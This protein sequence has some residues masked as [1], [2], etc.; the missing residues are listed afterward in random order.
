MSRGADLQPSPLS[1][2][3]NPG[4]N[5][6]AAFVT[7]TEAEAD[8]ENLRFLRT[9]FEASEGNI[10][11]PV[12]STSHLQ[13]ESA[14]ARR[15]H[16]RISRQLEQLNANTRPNY[17]GNAEAQIRRTHQTHDRLTRVM[18]RISRVHD[19][20]REAGRQA[21][22]YLAERRDEANPPA[23]TSDT[24][25]VQGV[26]SEV[27][28]LRDI[29][30]SLRRDNPHVAPDVSNIIPSSRRA[31]G[32]EREAVRSSGEGSGENESSSSILSGLQRA[33]REVQALERRLDATER[34][35]EFTERHADSL[36]STAIMQ[37]AR[38][39]AASTE[40]M[41]RYIRNREQLGGN[42]NN[43]DHEGQNHDST[44]LSRW[45]RMSRNTGFT[46]APTTNTNTIVP[47]LRTV[48]DDPQAVRTEG[49]DAWMRFFHHTDNQQR[50]NPGR[51]VKAHQISVSPFLIN[52]VVYL[53]RLRHCN[54][55][56]DA[57]VAA[58]EGGFANKEFFADK[59]DDF[60]MDVSNFPPPLRSSW[61]QS[62]V[63]FS[64]SQHTNFQQMAGAQNGQSHISRVEARAASARDASS[65]QINSVAQVT[66]ARAGSSFP[67][68]E[69]WPVKVLLHA[70]DME[71]MT[72]SGTM[73]AYDI[74]N[75]CT[76]KDGS[77]KVPITT[78]LEGQIIDLKTH[79]FLTPQPPK[80]ATDQRST[81]PSAPSTKINFPGT[82]AAIDA[83][84]WRRLPPFSFISDDTEV[85]RLMLSQDR[86]AAVNDEYIFMRWKERCFIH[87]A[88]DACPLSP[89]ARRRGA[90]PLDAA[91]YI[92]HTGFAQPIPRFPRSVVG[93]G[94]DTDCGH[95]LTISGFYYVSL[96]RDG[97]ELAGLYY[98][99]SSTPYQFLHLVGERGGRSAAW[100]F[101]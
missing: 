51:G 73:E 25:T 74:P 88:G 3:S 72:L 81:S 49:E 80:S 86:M 66:D 10:A 44:L 47:E 84:N 21:A 63:R 61:L 79:S 67:A 32:N 7:P 78:F 34:R 64:G 24:G 100:A 65:G 19:A 28:E 5:I 33:E 75:H 23:A 57:L 35:L 77:K 96:R 18:S 27:A 14:E 70:V 92:S 48:L 29:L 69:Q 99:Q 2:T 38:T 101:R 8:D 12:A 6:G 11:A 91:R 76:P 1:Y 42:N 62:G 68:L 13:A 87:R 26:V 46:D 83:G 45:S 37:N 89:S 15:R 90:S 82:S 98:D 59:H 39:N 85:S 43:N 56:D 41:L 95:G 50:Q 52:T 71:S 53:E 94:D 40:R 97:G 36:R 9:P 55:Y 4:P 31:V 17:V 20:G 54:S 30:E 60:I 93:E 16:T 58:I 22:S